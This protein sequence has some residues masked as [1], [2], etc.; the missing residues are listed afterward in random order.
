VSNVAAA[1]AVV[2]TLKS[3]VPGGQVV[4]VH[5]HCDADV[6]LRVMRLGINEFLSLPLQTG[7]LQETFGRVRDRLA[8][9]TG[10]PGK[11]GELISFLPARPGVGTTTTTVNTALAAASI[12]DGRVFL[13]D[14]D[15]ACGLVRF[16]LKIQSSH[17]IQDAADRVLELDEQVWPQIVHTTG[18]LDIAH[19]GIPMVGAKLGRMAIEHLTAFLR[20][21]Y[22]YGFA[23]LSGQ[24]EDFSVEV[25]TASKHIFVV[26]TPELTA[27]HQARQKVRVLEE[28]GLADRTSIILNRA[29]RSSEFPAIEVEK[30]AGASVHATLPEDSRN[31]Q[32]ALAEGKGVAAR[33]ELG[34]G[35]QRLARSLMSARNAPPRK[36]R[37]IEYFYTVPGRYRLEHA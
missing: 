32:H 36:K 20:G 19:A 31:V 4:A 2:A 15:L 30:L 33:S 8:G 23:D 11:L 22:S 6:L 16:M 3:E 17:S 13:G 37:F 28:L 10:A 5:S 25:M 21:R 26:T 24:L 14:F 12:A 35:Y 9:G 1:E 29:A 18:N 27:L 7:A 34:A